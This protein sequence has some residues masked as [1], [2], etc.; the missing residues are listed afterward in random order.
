[1]VR[2][3]QGHSGTHQRLL[4]KD[5]NVSLF[6]NHPGRR[7]PPAVFRTGTIGQIPGADSLKGRRGRSIANHHIRQNKAFTGCA[8]EDDTVFP[9]GHGHGF[10]SL[11]RIAKAKTQRPIG[12]FLRMALKGKKDKTQGQTE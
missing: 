12:I 1:M 6:R 8:S 3:N 10:G 5:P 4:N 7:Q 2:G 9:T 11:A